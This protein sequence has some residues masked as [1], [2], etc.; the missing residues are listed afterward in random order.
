MSAGLLNRRSRFPLMPRPRDA[1][2]HYLSATRYL[3]W[4]PPLALHL[5]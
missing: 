4:A 5:A 2:S 1:N 3:Y